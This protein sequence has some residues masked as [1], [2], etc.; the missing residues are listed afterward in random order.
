MPKSTP[1]RK[2]YEFPGGARQLRSIEFRLNS[3]LSRNPASSG[4][5]QMTVRDIE[6]NGQSPYS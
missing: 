3:G 4:T 1:P 2:K 5:A 6:L